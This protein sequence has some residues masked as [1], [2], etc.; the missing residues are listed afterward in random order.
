[1]GFKFIDELS[2]ITPAFPHVSNPKVREALVA[3]L[4]LAAFPD[5]TESIN[6]LRE[7]ALQLIGLE[8]DLAAAGPF[9]ADSLTFQRLATAET[10]MIILS[11]DD[12]KLQTFTQVL[13][14]VWEELSSAYEDD[15]SD[16]EDDE[17][18]EDDSDDDENDKDEW[19]EDYDEEDDDDGGNNTP[20]GWVPPVKS[21]DRPIHAL[22]S[23][24]DEEET[25]SHHEE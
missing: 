6:E 21:P 16:D 11:L 9:M 17:D 12:E 3:F 25:E 14:S 15:D 2:E 22:P 20:K 24:E 8:D 7:F 13:Q 4:S 23:H 10:V 1:M 19:D 18:D 5:A